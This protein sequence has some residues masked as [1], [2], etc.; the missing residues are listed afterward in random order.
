MCKWPSKVL[1]QNGYFPRRSAFVNSAHPL[2]ETPVCDD[3][4]FLAADLTADLAAGL[5]ADNTATSRTPY[6]D[7]QPLHTDVNK[8]VLNWI[9]KFRELSETFAVTILRILKAVKPLKRP[10]ALERTTECL[11]D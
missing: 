2:D 6:D 7:Q 3:Q 4:Q 10:R 1:S 5:A 9:P 11:P 8:L